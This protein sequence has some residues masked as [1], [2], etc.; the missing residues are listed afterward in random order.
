MGHAAWL[1][2]APIGNP[3]QPAGLNHQ[4][5]KKKESAM[6]GG[7]ATVHPSDATLNAM[8]PQMVMVQ[9]WITTRSQDKE[10]GSKTSLCPTP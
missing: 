1:S 3:S 6:N 9:K 8:R 10:E 5:R 7:A 2:F 4:K